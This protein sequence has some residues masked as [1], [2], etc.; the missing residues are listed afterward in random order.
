MENGKLFISP[1]PIGNLEDI[2][3]RVLRV[4]EEV[5][6]IAAEDTRRSIKLL[7]HYNIKNTLTSYHEHNERKKG[8]NL[9]EELKKGKNIAL[10]SDAGMPGISDPGESLIK[11]AIEE[12]IE[13]VV[14]PGPSAA[15]TALVASG[16]STEKFRFEGFLSSRK[17]ER[18]ERL[19][20]LKL[21]KDTLIFYE[22]PHRLKNTLKDMLDIFGNRNSALI[23]ELTKIYEEVYRADIESSIEKFQIE[24]PKGEFVL[25]VEGRHKGDE[26]PEIDIKKELSKYIEEGYTKKASVKIVTEKYNLSKNKVYKE[27]LKL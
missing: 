11:L 2:T 8:K 7:N 1:T 24:S 20:E 21:E 5:D 23:R 13:V 9:I 14:L 12:N 4:L 15:I 3:I 18:L 17:K 10:I 27:S 25:V 26:L 19:E 22:S 6:M 16:L